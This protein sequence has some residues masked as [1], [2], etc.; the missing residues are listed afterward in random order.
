ML[1]IVRS[2]KPDVAI[3][4]SFKRSFFPLGAAYQ[5]SVRPRSHSDIDPWAEDTTRWQ[6]SSIPTSELSADTQKFRYVLYKNHDR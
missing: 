2:R 1:T 6:I 4:E 3:I 5:L